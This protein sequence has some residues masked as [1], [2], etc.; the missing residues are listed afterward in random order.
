MKPNA[1]IKSAFSPIKPRVDPNLVRPKYPP[2]APSPA[3]PT[4]AKPQKPKGPAQPPPQ[5]LPT[6]VLLLAEL[7]ERD[8]RENIPAWGALIKDRDRAAVVLFVNRKNWL[9]ARALKMNDAKLVKWLAATA[10]AEFFYLRRRP[11]TLALYHTL[12]GILLTEDEANVHGVFFMAA[13]LFDSPPWRSIESLPLY[14]P[15]APLGQ[16]H[17]VARVVLSKTPAESSAV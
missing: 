13:R 8:D 1:P 17:L 16:R 10:L 3:T 11:V 5:P 7:C 6:E 15:D 14:G 9:M 2:T 4:Q 12:R